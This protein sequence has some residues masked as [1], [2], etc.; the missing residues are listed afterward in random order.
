VALLDELYV[1][2]E[3]RGGGIGASM[4]ELM[5]WECRSRGVELVEIEV[6]DV[7]VDAARFYRRHGY[8]D[9]DP[10]SGD[11][12][13]SFAKELGERGSIAR[14]APTTRGRDDY[15]TA[16]TV[17]VPA[18]SW[19]ARST[20]WAEPSAS[21][22]WHVMTG[23]VRATRNGAGPQSTAAG[24]D[25]FWATKSRSDWVGMTACWVDSATVP[26][27]SVCSASTTRHVPGSC[28][29]HV[30]ATPRA[31]S[32]PL[33]QATLPNASCGYAAWTLRSTSRGAA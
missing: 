15:L 17:T 31:R 14:R 28:T 7:D 1:V 26:L 2:P 6:D 11:R 12:A 30:N 20:S 13:S 19:T 24:N 4:I 25:E 32:T 33:G 21:A 18:V 23:P 29:A 27:P 16:L 9:V 10:D 3:R 8:T 5:E 22:A